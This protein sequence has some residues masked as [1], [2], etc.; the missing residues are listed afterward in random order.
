M[1]DWWASI[2]PGIRSVRSLGAITVTS[3]R[4]RS[5]TLGRLI[6]ATISPSASRS[7]QLSLPSTSSASA[8]STSA[9]K[10]GADS[11]GLSR[12]RRGDQV[13]QVGQRRADRSTSSLGSTRLA[14]TATVCAWL[15][16][17][18]VSAPSAAA[19]ICSGV[20]SRPCT[21]ST[22]GEPRFAAILALKDS[23][24]PVETSV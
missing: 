24:V 5:S 7:I 9:R 18:S 19:R 16:R 12:D 22:T 10:V 20:R 2:R 11:T 8:A 21:T 3:G 23:S 15:A 13:G 6:A 17:S 14:T 1:P 4:S